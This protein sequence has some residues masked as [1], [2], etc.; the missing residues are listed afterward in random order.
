MSTHSKACA[1]QDID[2]LHNDVAA[3]APSDLQ[4]HGALIPRPKTP[5]GAKRGSSSALACFGGGKVRPRPLWI[6]KPPVCTASS[7]QTRILQQVYEATTASTRTSALGVISG[8]QHRAGFRLALL[9]Q[10]PQACCGGRSRAG[11]ALTPTPAVSQLLDDVAVPVVPVGH[12]DT[13]PEREPEPVLPRGLV[14]LRNVGARCSVGLD[15][16][17]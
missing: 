9:H 11:L 14:G 15:Y 5:D 7:G 8:F 12:S 3:R 1:A 10:R 6:L 13:E 17:Y 16:Q 2:A 4:Q